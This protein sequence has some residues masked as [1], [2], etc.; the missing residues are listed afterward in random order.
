[1]TV[2]GG[3]MTK[4]IALALKVH[5]EL[6]HLIYPVTPESI[7]ASRMRGN[8]T[9]YS[10]MGL[11][12]LSFAWFIYA[13]STQHESPMAH[14]IGAAGLGATFQSLYTAS[15]YLR[16]ATF[17]AKYNQRYAIHWALGLFSGTILGLFGA[18]LLSDNVDG[19]RFTPHIL[20]LIGGFSS[21]AVAQLLQRVSE[22]LVTVVKGSNKERARAEAQ[23]MLKGHQSK[24]AAELLV[25]MKEDPKNLSKKLELLV[26]QLNKPL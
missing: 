1:M 16:N 5:A 19:F 18:E 24:L 13:L 6:S 23:M 12:V 25:L 15:K 10:I 4:D 14:V 20:A 7:R 26:A 9:F 22:T 21:E 8:T 2:A 17:T 11:G 3:F